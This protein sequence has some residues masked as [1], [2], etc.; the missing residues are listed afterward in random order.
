[1]KYKIKQSVEL[2]YAVVAPELKIDRRSKT[3]Q[4]HDTHSSCCV[5][6]MCKYFHFVIV[7][8]R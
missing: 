1:M 5:L 8:C 3:H 2:K 4:T 7:I 6:Y